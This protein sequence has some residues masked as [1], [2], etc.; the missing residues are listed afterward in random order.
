MDGDSR[1]HDNRLR[2]RV[3]RASHDDSASA[4]SLPAPQSARVGPSAR[5]EGAA[6]QR[7]RFGARDEKAP[8]NARTSFRSSADA[9]AR[10]LLAFA[11]SS[12]STGGGAVVEPAYD[13][14][15]R[16]APAR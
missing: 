9:W 10:D 12:Q 5:R 7:L 2:R 3:G 1:A 15:R 8:H 16:P 11:D 6:V 14:P 4:P 13:R